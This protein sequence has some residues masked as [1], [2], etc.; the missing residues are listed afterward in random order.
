MRG[1][2]LV[3]LWSVG[4]QCW[5]QE[6]FFTDTSVLTNAYFPVMKSCLALPEDEREDCSDSVMMEEIYSRYVVPQSVIDS[7]FHGITKIQFVVQTTGVVSEVEL[8]ASSGHEEMDS[9]I[10]VAI[11]QLPDFIPRTINGEV[12]E[13]TIVVDVKATEEQLET[14]KPLFWV[15]N[16]PYYEACSSLGGKERSAC[17]KA[18]ISQ[19]V[20][21]AYVVPNEAK[22]LGLQGTTY[23]KFVV[24]KF[25]KV[26]LVKVVK[27]SGYDILDQA[28]IHAV[29]NLPDFNPG[30]LDG[31]P[32]A[33]LYTIPIKIDFQKKSKKKKW[34]KS[35]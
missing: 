25:G 8:V 17:T 3:V 11:Q 35:N 14:D 24:N 21:D 31:V 33:V 4:F 32:V 18:I 20:Q 15:K 12:T 16:M 13:I 34:W 9:A 19:E 2:I 26:V 27:S 6:A 7:N 29:E 23:V 5:G 10:I 30:F 28:A 1:I 22:V